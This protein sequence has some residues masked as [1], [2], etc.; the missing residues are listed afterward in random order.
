MVAITFIPNPENKYAVNHINCNKQDNRLENLEW[1]TPS[2][3]V[4]HAYNTGLCRPYDR[5]IKGFKPKKYKKN[6]INLSRSAT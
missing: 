2:E 3:N 1:C 5:K 4:R 6:N